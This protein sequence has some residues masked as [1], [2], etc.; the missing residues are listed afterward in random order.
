MQMVMAFVNQAAAAKA[1]E[2]QPGI[3]PSGGVGY[4]PYGPTYTGPTGYNP[5]GGVGYEPYGP[6]YMGYNPSIYGQL[7]TKGND[8]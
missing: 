2:Q 4:E 8:Y 7:G 5:G 1:A 6:T 3:N